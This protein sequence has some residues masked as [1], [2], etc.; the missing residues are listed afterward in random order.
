MA[1]LHDV[2]LGGES[3]RAWRSWDGDSWPVE[4]RRASDAE[5]RP[6]WTSSAAL[7]RTSI[8]IRM[9]RAA[10]KLPRSITRSSATSGPPYWRCSAAVAFVLLIACANVAN[11]LLARS[12]A[13]QREIALRVASGRGPPAAVAAAHHRK[14]RTGVNRSQRWNVAGRI[15]VVRVLMAFSPITFP[16]FVH[17][18]ID[19]PVA[20]FTLVVSVLCGIVMGFAPA[21]HSRIA[22][23]HTALKEIVRKSQRRQAAAAFPRMPWWW[24]RSP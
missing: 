11:L 10:W 9:K 17:P 24:P 4:T 22:R 3:G 18:G 12:E 5:R 19:P 1:S 6:N 21:L 15:S 14:L 13:R 8:R 16:T 7:W 23:L 2:R 20:L